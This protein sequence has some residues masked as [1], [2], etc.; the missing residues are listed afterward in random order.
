LENLVIEK[1]IKSRIHGR[2]VLIL[3]DGKSVFALIDT[4]LEFGLNKDKTISEEQIQ[5]LQNAL[6]I[7]KLKSYSMKL[8][9]GFSRSEYQIRQKLKLKEFP[10]EEIQNTI[11]RLKE[12]G[13]IND[14][15]FSENFVNYSIRKKWGIGKIVRELE[16]RKVKFED[17]NELIENLSDEN[18]FFSNAVETAEKKLRILKSKPEIKQK[19]SIF[20]HLITKGYSY[21]IAKK[22]LQK[23]FSTN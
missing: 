9:E 18:D 12:I 15:K 3:S 5:L 19:D 16:I 17:Y 21:D 20:R 2:C 14:K 22:V 1:I 4:V 11:L 23:L 7:N 10:V 6:K 13:M 8:C